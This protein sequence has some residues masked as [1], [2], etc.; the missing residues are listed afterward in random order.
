M[1]AARHCV[2]TALQ[3]LL[4]TQPLSN[5]KVSFAWSVTVGPKI[6]QATSVALQSEGIL[7]LRAENRLWAQE[8]LRS[9]ALIISRLNRLLGADV[10]KRIELLNCETLERDSRR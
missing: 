2:T 6:D 9:S 4:K 1:I 10:V 7:N 8:V 3:T 5:S